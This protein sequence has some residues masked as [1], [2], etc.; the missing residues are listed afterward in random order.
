[1]SR[2]TKI[3]GGCGKRVDFNATCSCKKRNATNKKSGET[4]KLMKSYRWK[5]LRKRIIERD[6]CICQRCLIKYNIIESSELTV[7]HVLSRRNHPELM[8]DENNLICLCFTCNNQ[9]GTKN[10]LDFAWNVP[11]EYE[12]IL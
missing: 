12:P 11:D 6:G 8:F 5:Q 9:L 1:M 7:H 10:K 2:H 4:D 3:C